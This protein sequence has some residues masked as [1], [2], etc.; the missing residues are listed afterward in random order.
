MDAP[1]YGELLALLLVAKDE[2]ET[3]A[4]LLRLHFDRGENSSAYRYLQ[5]CVYFA[6]EHYFR[7]LEAF[8]ESNY[9]DWEERA[10]ARSP[11]ICREAITGSRMLRGR[12]GTDTR[13]PSGGTAAMN[14]CPLMNLRRM[15][16]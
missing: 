14:T 7:A 9:Q 15:N 8:E 6:Q 2:D 4:D 5:G 3:Y 11:H 1:A 10:A 12:T 16:I 13:M